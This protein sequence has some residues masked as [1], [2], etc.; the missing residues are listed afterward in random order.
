MSQVS[1]VNITFRRSFYSL[2]ET[3]KGT[4]ASSQES[5]KTSTRWSLEIVFPLSVLG[6]LGVVESLTW[7][8]GT[9]KPP[10]ILLLSTCS[11]KISYKREIRPILQGIKQGKTSILYGVKFVFCLL[12]SNALIFNYDLLS[13]SIS[14]QSWQTSF[15]LT[16][17]C[18]RSHKVSD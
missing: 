12:A 9:C 15:W 17:L 8:G 3:H 10:N 2:L 7:A 13:A 14:V 1:T 18:A 4:F 5:I 6:R 16:A 11:R